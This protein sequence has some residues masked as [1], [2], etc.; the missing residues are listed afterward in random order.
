MDIICPICK[1][2]TPEHYQEKH[3]LIPRGICKRNKYAKKQQIIEDNNTLD[4]CV[5]CGDFLHK[6]FT[7]KDLADNYNTLDKILANEDIQNWASWISKKLNDFTI[8]MKTKKK[9]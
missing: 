5:S 2:N 3:H 8:C 4:L 7:I 9:R 6:V 1:R